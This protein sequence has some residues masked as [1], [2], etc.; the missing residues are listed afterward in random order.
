MGRDILVR[1]TG[2]LIFYNKIQQAVLISQDS[3]LVAGGVIG[4]PIKI[5]VVGIGEITQIGVLLSHCDYATRLHSK[6]D[7]ARKRRTEKE[8]RIK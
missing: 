4:V 5:I 6:T 7:L 1:S 3:A 2:K 8:R